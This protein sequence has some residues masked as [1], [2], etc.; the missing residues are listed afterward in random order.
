MRELAEG[1]DS[2]TPLFFIHRGVLDVRFLFGYC[3]ISEN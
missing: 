2:M 1:V 3:E